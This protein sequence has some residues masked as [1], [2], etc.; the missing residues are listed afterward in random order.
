MTG[1]ISSFG[2][3][4]VCPLLRE[5]IDCRVNR[6]AAA[7]SV[8]LDRAAELAAKQN[9]EG[10]SVPQEGGD[11]RYAARVE[12]VPRHRRPAFPLVMA[13]RWAART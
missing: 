13:L 2:L 9:A 5:R 3:Q 11:Y 7:D 8:E 10:S 12:M 4:G 6:S 1:G